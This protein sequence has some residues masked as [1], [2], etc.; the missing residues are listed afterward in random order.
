[1]EHLRM[2]DNKIVVMGI[3][4][5]TSH[6]GHS[7]LTY[8][9]KKQRTIT[10]TYG[11]FSATDLAR[12]YSKQEV[13]EYGNI[14]SLFQC[15]QEIERIVDDYQPDF[16]VSESPFVYRFPQAFASLCLCVNA[17]QR[18]L[19]KTNRKL[20]L[21]A[22]R[23]AKKAIGNSMAGKEEVQEAI[24]HLPDLKIIHTKEKPKETMVEH[25]ADSIAIAYAFIHQVL[26]ELLKTN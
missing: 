3:D 21:I 17:I 25:E 11:C 12:K 4:P 10:E 20:Y 13:K 26:P 19:Y 1:M 5:S 6:L 2:Q 8:D 14:I 7:K 24:H 23:Q 22:P 9:I 18:A 16:V 15:E